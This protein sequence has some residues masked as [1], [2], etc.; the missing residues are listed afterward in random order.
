M[1][2]ADAAVVVP[3]TA[4]AKKTKFVLIRREERITLQGADGR[5][6]DYLVREMTGPDRD[7]YLQDMLNRTKRNPDGTT[8]ITQAGN[9]QSFLVS[10]CLYS[11]TVKTADGQPARVTMQEINLWPVTV[12]DAVFKL[13]QEV[14]GLDENKDESVKND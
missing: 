12:L 3:E 2:D 6:E 8:S 11:T 14:S 4:K 10:K 5:E 7:A 13:C 1:S 9:L